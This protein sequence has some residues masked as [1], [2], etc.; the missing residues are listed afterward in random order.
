MRNTS[1]P[2]RT[3]LSNLSGYNQTVKYDKLG[4]VLRIVEKIGAKD[5]VSLGTKLW[6]TSYS[7]ACA[8]GLQL[9]DLQV[10]CHACK[11]VSVCLRRIALSE[12]D[13]K[14]ASQLECTAAFCSALQSVAACLPATFH[15]APPLFAL[16]FRIVCSAPQHFARRRPCFS[17]LPSSFLVGG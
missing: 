4:N 8:A 3:V 17:R 2:F 7:D 13:H 6:Q 9:G 11:T 10:S 15:L 12:P 14:I 1:P 5:R 16:R